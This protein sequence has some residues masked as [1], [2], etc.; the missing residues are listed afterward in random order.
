MISD[1]SVIK[2]K[3]AGRK[4]KRKESIYSRLWSRNKLRSRK[5]LIPLYLSITKNIWLRAT[6]RVLWTLSVIC[7]SIYEENKAC[8]KDLQ[9][10][11]RSINDCDQV[12][13]LPRP[14]K[15]HVRI[16]A[17]YWVGLGSECHVGPVKAYGCHVVLRALSLALAPFRKM[18][19][20]W[21]V[22]NP[23]WSGHLETIR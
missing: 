6:A 15:V 18:C 10:S 2:R 11:L 5:R 20:T 12:N 22:Y 23:R 8:R 1:Y 19:K 21:L 16:S 3:R 4:E 17:A 7:R 13:R 9:S 14:F